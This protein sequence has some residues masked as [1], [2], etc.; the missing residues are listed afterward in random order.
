MRL[1]PFFLSLLAITALC[2]S[3]LAAQKAMPPQDES[4]PTLHAYSDLVQT[5]VIVL[6]QDLKPM[7]PVPETSFFV[8]LDGGPRFRVTHAR[9]EGDDPIS[10][11]ILLDLS[12]PFP[13]L[14]KNIGD[15]VAH[16]AP[17]SLDPRDRVSVYS[18]DCQLFL[19][20]SNVSAQPAA[21][22]QAVDLAL[23]S[24]TASGGKRSK[25]CRA[26]IYLWNSLIA[27]THALA[28]QPGHHVILA[29]TDGIDRGSRTSWSSLSV[30]AALSGVAI[31]GLSDA[32]T[33]LLFNNVSD[34]TGGLMLATE[35]KTLQ[36]DLQSFT[37]ILRG[38]YIVEFPRPRATTAGYHGMDIS[39]DK[40][41]AFIRAS[42]A[43]VPVDDPTI[44]NDPATVPSDPSH[45]PRLGKHRP[46][47]PN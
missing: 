22:K 18:L 35:P 19:S 39:I 45:A 27:I 47:P 2:I 15:A 32:P 5:A 26:P 44:L 38:R 37:A 14:M 20:E 42:G 4:V 29:V 33:Q 12:Q 28:H 11:A 9:L 34:S 23:H 25:D 10:L 36:K 17:L 1:A 43:Q 46:P 16:L 40:I 13:D 7:P 41:D 30:D 21:L 31:F 6:N 8:S 3:T 24:W